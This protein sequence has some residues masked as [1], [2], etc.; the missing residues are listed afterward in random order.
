MTSGSLQFTVTRAANPAS[1]AQ[2]VAIL[3]DP[4]FGTFHT[5]HMVSIDYTEGTGWHNARVIG[6]GPIELDPSAIV[7]HYAQEVFEGLKAYRWTDGSIVSFRAEANAARLRSSARRLA[8]PELPDEL[9]IESLCQLIAV[10]NAWVPQAGGEE[11]LYL[12]PFIIATEPGLGV[13]PAKEYRYL[14]IG[15]P[16]GAYFK[17]GVNPVSVWV[18]TEYV[19]ASPGGTGAAKC[20][21]NYAASLLAQAEAVDNGCDQVVWLDAVERRYVEEMGGMNIFFVFGSG[22]SARLVTPELSG[23]LLPGITRDSLLHL[24]I[25]AGV[26]VEE[27]KIDMAEW[28]KKAAVGEITEVFACGTAAVIT[29]VSRVKCGDVE[30]TIAD[31]QPGELTMALRD[32]LTGIQRGTF[33]DTHGWMSRL[34]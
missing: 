24:A 30:F 34:G 27:R 2:R 22:G 18:S 28:Q 3:Q 13:R 31:G 16:A 21:G 5:D 20:G 4:G 14:L 17:G 7:L 12:R 6:Y 11:A 25:D 32:T 9:F 19:R 26:T 15:S 29:P 1:D 10:D 33:A 23:S 8:I